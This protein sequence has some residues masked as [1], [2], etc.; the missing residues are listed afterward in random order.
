M[1][2]AIQAERIKLVSVRSPYWCLAT[3]V[4]LAVGITTLIATVGR[5]GFSTQPADGVTVNALLTGLNQLAIV[6][7]I[8]MSVLAMTSEF[9]FGTIRTSFLAVPRRPTVLVAKA[10]VYLALTL[11]TVFVL[12]VVCLLIL[13]VGLGRV[14]AFDNPNVIRQLW[15]LPLYAMLCVLIGLGVGAMIRHTAGAISLVLIWMLV[16]ETILAN[17]P[18]VSEY[19][20]PFMPFTN[21]DRFLSGGS[22]V[23]DAASGSADYFHWNPTVSLVYFAVIAIAVFIGGVALTNARDA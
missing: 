5:G 11:V 8:V 9:R 4:L 10:A 18:K 20:G 12:T 7:L 15:G 23:S 22:S 14:V 6:V 21:A 3:A 17:A 1:I 19:V 16:V 13:R 2:D